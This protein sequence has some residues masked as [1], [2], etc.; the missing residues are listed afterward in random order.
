MMKQNELL[1]DIK[2]VIS[3]MKK[4]GIRARYFTYTVA[5]SLCVTLL[6]AY[7]VSLLL[8]LAD[9][10]IKGNFDQIRHMKVVGHII[11]YFPN[12]FDST[13]SLFLL[14]VG[15]IYLT[16]AIK[17][18]LRFAASLS[19][20]EQS[21]RATSK[22][23]E[24]LLERYL[25]YS[26]G[27][28]DK[29]KISNAHAT[30]TRSTEVIEKQF[31]LFQNF[32]IE[33]LL[34]VVYAGMMILISWKLTLVSLLAFPIINLLTRKIII[35]IQQTVKSAESASLVFGDRALNILNAIPVIKSFTKEN[36]E[37]E[38]FRALS[39][40][41]LRHN[42]KIQKLKGLVDPIEE[43]GQTTATLFVALGMALMLYLDRSLDPA[44]VFVFFYLATKIM[45]GL[46]A[47]NSFRIGI[48]SS[49]EQVK[50]INNI[51]DENKE[52]I[53]PEGSKHFDG[54]KRGIEIRNLNFS[55][56]SSDPVL[57]G[58]NFVINK[59]EITAMVGATGSGKSTITNL[60]LRFYDSPKDTIFIDDVDIREYNVESLRKKISHVGQDTL[61]FPTSIEQN[62][63]YGSH[64]NVSEEQIFDVGKKA[65]VHKFAINLP[66]KYKTEVT[67]RGGNLSGGE[68][69]RISIARA[70]IK[71]FD[72]LI[73]D[74]AT[75]ATDALTEAD[76]ISSLKKLGNN[77]TVLMISH[78]LS[79][80]KH[81]DKIIYIES[82]QVKE[83]GTFDHLISLKG[84][85]YRLWQAQ[86]A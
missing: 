21:K 54:L 59:G 16:I 73:L 19:V 6:S 64:E 82:G 45:P 31:K 40:E 24:L 8:P 42:I 9:G 52:F 25:S 65:A 20:L 44:Q 47:I 83:V 41:E 27:Y 85:F 71:D 84:G 18:I 7:M 74:E 57:K 10:V 15:W 26:K 81:A 36:Y 77:K 17:S 3:F 43:I 34:L 12:I 66:N 55:F 72:V 67:D 23:R 4:S 56:G 48:V 76:I 63:S 11:G 37:K 75:S 70:L 51:L 35:K 79:T 32:V 49:G 14:L 80:I 46:N 13:I 29:N 50:A 33:M 39:E 62:I 30:L 58:I 53:L 22:L 69:Q 68:K 86:N 38:S 60:L 5:L 78:R 61:L 2:Q 28:Y 1:T